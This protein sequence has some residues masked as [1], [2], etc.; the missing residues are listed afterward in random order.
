MDMSSEARIEI[1]LRA[2][3]AETLAFSFPMGYAFLCQA[4]SA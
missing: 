4:N 2:T 3:R 1:L